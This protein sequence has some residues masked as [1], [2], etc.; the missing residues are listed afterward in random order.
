MSLQMHLIKCTVI[1]HYPLSTSHKRQ[2]KQPSQF[3]N[4]TSKLNQLL[5][6]T[7]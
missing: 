3:P 6:S 4:M 7:S 1:N 5:Y 2:V